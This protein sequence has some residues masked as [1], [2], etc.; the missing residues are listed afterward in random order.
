MIIEKDR[1]EYVGSIYCFFEFLVVVER[2][3]V[4]RDGCGVRCIGLEVSFY[5]FWICDFGFNFLIL[6]FLIWK[7]GLIMVFFF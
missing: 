1:N 2:L 4:R 7:I 5:Y 3:V 6:S